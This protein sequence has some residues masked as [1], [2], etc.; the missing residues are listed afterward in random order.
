[1]INHPF[2]PSLPF[3]LF[4]SIFGN[5]YG[6]EMW[7]KFYKAMFMF[8]SYNFN[9]ILD[10]YWHLFH[11]THQLPHTPLTDLPHH[12]FHILLPP[13]I[14]IQLTS[15]I[16]RTPHTVDIPY[17]GPHIALTTTYHWPS[18]YHWLH[19]PLAP[20]TNDQTYNLPYIPRFSHCS[21]YRISQVG[22]TSHTTEQKHRPK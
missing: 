4:E 17:H 3:P 15:K 7:L 22:F 19:I 2:E 1:M 6:L 21:T 16:P 14:Y 20:H 18:K 11:L 10:Y 8:E 12:W 9:Y 5:S 13:Q